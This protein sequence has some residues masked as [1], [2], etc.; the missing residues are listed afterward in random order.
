LK[1]IVTRPIQ[2]HLD[3]L[4]DPTKEAQM[5]QYFESVFHPAAM[6]FHGF[7][8]LEM[9]KLRTAAVGSAPAGMN[10]RFSLSYESEEL[11]QKWV[12][13]DVHTA[14]WGELE[15]TFSSTS[16]NVPIFDIV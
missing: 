5:L 14:V 10:Y 12:A 2:L 11:R 6:K 16:Y 4:V 1:V 15:K 13:S 8:D 3:L 9:L 7:I